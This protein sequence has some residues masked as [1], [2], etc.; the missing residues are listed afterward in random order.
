M[1]GFSKWPEETETGRAVA[2]IAGEVRRRSD[3]LPGLTSRGLANLVNGFSKWPEGADCC[4]AT[5]AIARE[6]LR[7]QLS[8]FAPQDLPNLVNGFCKWPE[9]ARTRQATVGIAA[10]FPGIITSGLPPFHR[11]KRSAVRQHPDAAQIKTKRKSGESYALPAHVAAEATRASDKVDLASCCI[12]IDCAIR[13]VP[14]PCSNE[15]IG[16]KLD[17]SMD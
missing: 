3:R 16:V 13:R 14:R 5:L 2:A 9:A 6:V 1:N 7:R 11:R 12:N 10:D 15:V 8:D 17:E 4:E